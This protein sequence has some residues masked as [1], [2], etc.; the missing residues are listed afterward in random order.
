MERFEVI[1][2]AQLV[3]DSNVKVSDEKMPSLLRIWPD[4]NLWHV[5][6]IQCP[7]KLTQTV[8]IS[9]KNNCSVWYQ[10]NNVAT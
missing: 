9:L 8:D 3:L 2:A 10:L 7:Q 4:Q 5:T 6:Y 1:F